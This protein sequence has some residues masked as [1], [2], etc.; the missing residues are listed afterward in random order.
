MS[1]VLTDLFKLDDYH[2]LVMVDCYS[3]CT[4][5]GRL[6]KLSTSAI[7]DVLEN[8]FLE[9][10]YLNVI[11][12]D[13]G[14]QYRSK[15]NEFCEAK[16]ITKETSSPYNPQSNELAVRQLKFILWLPRSQA[17]FILL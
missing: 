5:I 12:L 11:R 2:Y 3:G 9:Y 8:C 7:I 14:P 15:F 16:G 17:F 4:F 10:G 6:R 13:S 1:H